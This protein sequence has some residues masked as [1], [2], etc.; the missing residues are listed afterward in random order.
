MDNLLR[1][2]HDPQVRSVVATAALLVPR[3]LPVVLLTPIFGGNLLPQRMRVGLTLFLVIVLTPA[4]VPQALAAATPS[5]MGYWAIAAKELLIGL[6]LSTMILIMYHTFSAFGAVVDV[7]RGATIANVF[8]PASQQQQSI[9]SSFFL[10]VAIVLFLTIGGP[11]VII[12]AWGDSMKSLPVYEPLPA[13]LVG[14][15]AGLQIISMSADLFVVAIRLAAPAFLVLVLLD[16]VL[17]LLNR[18]APQVQVYF[19]GLTVKSTLGLVMV[20]LSLGVTF[21]LFHEHFVNALQS[22]RRWILVP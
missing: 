15:E 16:V 13:H 12:D 20:L 11:H 4:I 1:F 19:L 7:S 3:V 9:F 10:Q 18:V 5:G 6:T 22:I 17:G 8:D 21:S 14:Q 2:Y